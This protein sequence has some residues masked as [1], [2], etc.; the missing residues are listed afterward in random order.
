MLASLLLFLIAYVSS[1]PVLLY[2]FKYVDY[3]WISPAQKQAYI[4]SGQYIKENNVITGLKWYEGEFY[5]TVPRWRRG[6]PST[7]NKLVVKDDQILLQPYPSWEMQKIGIG[8][9]LQ[10][11]Q[12]MEIDKRGWMWILDVGRLNILDDEKYVTPGQPKLVIW[13]MNQNCLIQEYEFPPE[14][15]SPTNSF[16]NDIVVDQKGGW[17]YISDTWDN[18]GII[19]YNYFENRAVR[20]DHESLHGNPNN[21]VTIDGVTY[22]N[23]Q[24]P[25]DGIAL[26]PTHL[27][28]CAVSTPGLY[29][30]E[31][32]KLNLYYS[33]GA[34]PSRFVTKIGDKNGLADG[35]TT[36]SSDPPA[37]YYGDFV[38]GAVCKWTT[39]TRFSSTV[40]VA[41]DSKTMQWPDTFAWAKSNLLFTSNRLQRYFVK[42]MDF[43]EVNF[44]IWSVGTNTSSYINGT[45][46]FPALPPAGECL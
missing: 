6:V 43:N 42:T 33:V 17:A 40:A 2:E 25:S 1:A 24:S 9:S 5:L 26:T 7:L 13:D 37:L 38:N 30:I 10:Y 4:E 29:S 18:G 21:V 15:L 41:S 44:R 11:V 45:G 34:D 8:P 28:W 22:T 31:T 14:V 3:D 16:A 39:G 27:Y 23:I 32:P 35:L 46:F 19:I 36:D 20:F 12:S